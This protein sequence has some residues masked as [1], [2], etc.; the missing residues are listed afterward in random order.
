MLPCKASE[1]LATINTRG[2]MVVTLGGE[3]GGENFPLALSKQKVTTPLR[4]R[5][6]GTKR[7]RRRGEEVRETMR[8]IWRPGIKENAN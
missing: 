7:Q 2:P 3:S 8:A 6:S 5:T 4:E 1:I